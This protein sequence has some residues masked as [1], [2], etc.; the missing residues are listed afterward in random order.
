M[1]KIIGV[2]FMIFMIITNTA[3]AKND[4]P[5]SPHA[6]LK[7]YTAFSS[8][9]GPDAESVM[10]FEQAKEKMFLLN[11]SSTKGLN[12]KRQ[13]RTADHLKAHT[14]VL[15]FGKNMPFIIPKTTT[16]GVSVAVLKSLRKTGKAKLSL[17]YDVNL[18]RLDGELTLIKK[19][20]K[21]PVLIGDTILNI[22]ILQ[23]QGKFHS[24]GR[25]AI[26]DF[27]IHDST[28]NPLIIDYSIQF[29]WEQLPRT[30]RLIYI[31]SGASQ[32]T[33]MEKSL[34]TIGKYTIFGIHFDFDKATIQP[35]SYKLIDDIA[36]T[37]RLNPLW[38]LKIEGHTDSIGNP[39]YNQK[40]SQQRAQSIKKY[41]VKHGISSKRLTTA[42]QGEAK[43]IASNDTLLGRKQNRRVEL[44]RTDN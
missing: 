36:Q 7:L 30:E 31:Q 34:S 33:A 26:G 3:N 5:F 23:V 38:T 9:K 14:L 43:P 18:N 4:G 10:I 1:K 24:Q 22:P 12:V 32:R 17:I 28:V 27:F 21:L 29:S 40:L 42:G 6:G 16:L 13:F 41:L 37:L 2:S 19:N 44:H 25:T 39:A 20:T 11:Y 15:G 35:N 8:P